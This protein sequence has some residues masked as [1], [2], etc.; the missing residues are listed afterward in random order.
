M[1]T[2]AFQMD[3]GW[4]V[5][6]PSPSVPE[7][8]VPAGAVDAHCHVFGPGD[9]FPYAP[10]R[11][12]TPCD[13]SKGQLFS[14]RDHLG[15]ER[16]VIVQAT[17]HGA[18]NRALVDAME[19]SGGK[20][21][22][23]A[24]VRRDVADEE[25]DRLH[26]AGVRGVRF[27][28]VKRLVDAL[29]HETLQEIGKRIQRLGW[30]LVIYFES[31]DLPELASFFA[32]LPGTVVFDHMGRP[33]VSK[34]PDGPEFDR[35]VQLLRENENMWAKVSCPDRLSQDG[36]PAYDDVVPFARRVVETFPDRVLWGTDWPH[37]NMKS[38]MPDDGKLVDYIPKI[39]VT[40]ELQQKLLVDNPMRLYWPE[41][42]D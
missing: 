17:C 24:S 26:E 16:N 9:E 32:T 36:P 1:S 4:L 20:A 28:F 7:F 2:P 22:G 35:F 39:A 25:L 30:H 41:E 38:H 33:D 3:D 37:P 29:P 23:V 6:H 34:D 21:R 13:A 14:L 8:K 11:K 31:P 12:Y 19:H 40:D 42:V 15:F 18:D 10:E 27:S 5:Y